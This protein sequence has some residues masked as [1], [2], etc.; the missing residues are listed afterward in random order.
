MG[1][2]PTGLRNLVRCCAKAKTKD[3][4]SQEPSAVT[5]IRGGRRRLFP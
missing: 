2:V 5:N 3:L 4:K 1:D